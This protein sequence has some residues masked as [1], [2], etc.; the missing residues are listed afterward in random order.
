MDSTPPAWLRSYKAQSAIIPNFASQ[1]RTELDGN[2]ATKAPPEPI[3]SEKETKG[4]H[5]NDDTTATN[6]FTFPSTISLTL[7]SMVS[8]DRT[9]SNSTPDSSPKKASFN[10][11]LEQHPALRQG[12]PDLHDRPQE[13]RRGPIC[14]FLAA[15]RRAFVSKTQHRLAR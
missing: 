6:R 8:L 7:H 11:R 3:Q 1:V 14:R 4:Y 10:P 5:A 15:I 9:Y 2:P 13:K 12:G